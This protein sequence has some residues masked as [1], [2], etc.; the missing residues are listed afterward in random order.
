MRGFHH[1]G[2][3]GKQSTPSWSSV[4]YTVGKVIKSKH[5]TIAD[6]YKVKE[7]AQDQIY[8]RGD[9]QLIE[10]PIE[11]IPVKP[12][13]KRQTEQLSLTDGAFSIEAE[14]QTQR[15]RRERKQTEQFDFNIAGLN[16][17]TKR[18]LAKKAKETVVTKEKQST[19]KATTK[20]KADTLPKQSKTVNV[21][22]DSKR[23]GKQLF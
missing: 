11:E 21:T 12:K 20:L 22:A 23:Q 5:P 7:L 3:L 2:T 6:K 14:K 10:G 15:E 17:K 18:T 16:D 19:K 1:K 13:K 9:L 8:S 4:I